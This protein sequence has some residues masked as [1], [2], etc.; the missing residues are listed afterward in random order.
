MGF[1]LVRPKAGDE[2][3]GDEDGADSDPPPGS[4]VDAFGFNV[5]SRVQTG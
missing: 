2:T 5:S 1:S 3:A 4:T